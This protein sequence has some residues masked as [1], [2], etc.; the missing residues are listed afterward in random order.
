MT[1]HATWRMT[2]LAMAAA[3]ALVVTG[4]GGGG[5]EDAPADAAY[6]APPGPGEMKP[7]PKGKRRQQTGVPLGL[8]PASRPAGASSA[9]SP[10]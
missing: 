9:P 6:V 4:C 10:A 8:V 1:T 5:L 7:A 2:T 3:L